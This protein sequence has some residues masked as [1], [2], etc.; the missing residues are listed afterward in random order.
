MFVKEMFGPIFF[1]GM[2]WYIELQKMFIFYWICS[3]VKGNVNGL[4]QNTNI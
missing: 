3:F 4:F 2:L 1:K